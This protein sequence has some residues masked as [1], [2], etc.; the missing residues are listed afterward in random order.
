MA[1]Q[2]KDCKLS[3]NFR[4]LSGSL[5]LLTA[6][7]MYFWFRKGHYVMARK[8]KLAFSW[9]MSWLILLAKADSFKALYLNKRD[10]FPFLSFN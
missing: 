2:I 6:M 9:M 8:T 5:N 1:T 10:G 7:N 3:V 4:A